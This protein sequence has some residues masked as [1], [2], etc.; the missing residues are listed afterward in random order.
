MTSQKPDEISCPCDP[1]SGDSVAVQPPS[2][3]WIVTVPVGA[4]DGVGSVV[5]VNGSYVAWI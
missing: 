2:W 5:S 3:Y 4:A 1:D